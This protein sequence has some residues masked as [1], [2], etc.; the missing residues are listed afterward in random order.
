[1]LALLV[2][3]ALQ[4]GISFAAAVVIGYCLKL[5]PVAGRFFAELARGIVEGLAAFAFFAILWGYY[6]WFELRWNGQ[7]PGKKAVGIRVIREGGYP[8]DG[9]AVVV[10]N[11]LRVIDGMPVV[12]IG[13]LLLGISSH[14]AVISELSTLPILIALVCILATRNYQRLGDVAAGTLV[15]KQRGPRVPTLEALAP[16]N[17]VLPEHLAK[18]AL[19]EISAHVA[20]MTP[21]EYRAVRW[22]SDRRRQ[23][24]PEIQQS[25]AMLLAVPLMSRLGIIPPAGV[26]CVNYADLLEYLAVAFEQHRGAL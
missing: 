15:I 14:N 8:V 7:T 23:L 9:F 10:R 17:A 13:I 1:M 5:S 4:L 26:L 3:Q 18:Y 25:T 11:L 2:D 20:E 22:Y 16:S 6:I 12:T 21:H 24:A 19:N